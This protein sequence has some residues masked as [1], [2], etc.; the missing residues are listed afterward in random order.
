MGRRDVNKL[1][2]A[3]VAKRKVRLAEEADNDF[4]FLIEVLEG[5]VKIGEPEKQRFIRLYRKL[6]ES[7]QYIGMR[8]GKTVISNKF[9]EKVTKQLENFD[10][11][12]LRR[13][14]RPVP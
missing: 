4:N 13:A 7:G 12:I 9:P 5:N 10:D 3:M 6:L 11:L 8:Q 2:D 14:S 1:V